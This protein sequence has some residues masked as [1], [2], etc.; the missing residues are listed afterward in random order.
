MNRTGNIFSG[1]LVLLILISG[2]ARTVSS[3]PGGPK[4]ETPPKLVKSVP[5]NGSTFFKEKSITVTFDEYVVFDK[6]SEKFMV[7]P[8]MKT[9]PEITLR[10]K[11]VF[12][13]FKDELKD[14]TTYTLYFQDAI[15]DVNENNPLDNFQFVFST[16]KY[17]DS[18]S[19]TGNVYYSHD[20]ESG[21]GALVLLHSL[22]ADSA[23][24][25]MIPDYV[26]LA[27]RNGIFRVD[28]MKPGKYR[29]Y[30]LLDNN[31]NKRY[32]LADEGFAFLD[33][34]ITVTPT[35][36]HL[37]P[38][39]PDTVKREVRD[40]MSFVD[41]SGTMYDMYLFTAPRKAYWLT[42]SDR[43]TA[44][45]LTYSVSL[46]PDTMDFSF[47]LVDPVSDKYEVFKS[48]DGDTLTVWLHDSLIYSNPVLRT[49]VTYPFTDSLKNVVSR[50]DSIPMRFTPLKPVRGKAKN[51][52]KVTHNIPAR[53]IRQGSVISFSSQTPLVEADTSV[54]RLYELT[55]SGRKKLPYSFTLD[56]ATKMKQVLSARFREKN[57]YLLTYDKK[58]FR[59]IY[60][61]VSD[62]SGVSFQMNPKE[63]YGS[64][65]FNVTGVT[66]NV[67]IQLMD[68]G[69]KILS[70]R[71]MNGGGIAEFPFLDK[72]KFKA[73]LI[74]DI[75]GDG[76]WTT[77]D[78]D[79]GLQP[80]PA[81]YYPDIVE[82]KIDW[83]SEYNWTVKDRNYKN[84]KMRKKDSTSR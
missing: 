59:D 43:K 21:K 7:S 5:S 17:L 15:R 19:V 14:S 12:I 27:N 24:R 65:S 77:G 46:P 32:D 50:T 28:N 4:D 44:Y 80:E 11:S 8:P 71:K 78:F 26:T 36:N 1:C 35:K 57:R 51:I 29:L 81:S 41:R 64:L 18:L 53:G 58:A 39:V 79:T 75:N 23:P 2:C 84:Q 61:N 33:S 34:I 13:N 55:E 22:Q 68:E 45:K 67:I 60:G 76:K 47:R 73:R 37:P 52:L 30:A 54:I 25:K 56:T 48:K 42:S 38:P 82:A 70:E 62:S 63:S 9:K 20:L 40:T 6:L 10:G 66:G 3:L 69:E 83:I 49:V 16:G 72:G 31:N 74:F